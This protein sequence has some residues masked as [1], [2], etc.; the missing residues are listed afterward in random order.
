VSTEEE[1]DIAEVADEIFNYLSDHTD[2]VDSEEAIAQWLKQHDYTV[3]LEDIRRAL[4]YLK[5]VGLVIESPG[6]H[7]KMLYKSA[8]ASTGEI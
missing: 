7:G 8:Y 4:D 6:R 2:E 3:G 1:T 5:T